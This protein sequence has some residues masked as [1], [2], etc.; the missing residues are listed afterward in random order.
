MSIMP[1]LCT[2]TQTITFV[3]DMGEHRGGGGGEGEGSSQLENIHSTLAQ[4]K[5]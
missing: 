4:L 5:G 2:N 3:H 1:T